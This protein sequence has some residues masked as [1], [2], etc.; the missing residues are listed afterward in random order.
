MSTRGLRPE[1]DLREATDAE[2]AF[3]LA[4]SAMAPG[5]APMMTAVG[6]EKSF[7]LMTMLGGRSFRIPRIE[8]F[9]H[10]LKLV[11]AAME[12]RRTGEPIPSVAARHGVPGTGLTAFVKACQ[13]H[14]E[15]MDRH[16]DAADRADIVSTWNGP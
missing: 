9:T 13:P 8:E 14:W 16:R 15:A 6:L 4:I 7:L 3:Y 12:Q 1:L 5:L 2:Q 11:N 10:C